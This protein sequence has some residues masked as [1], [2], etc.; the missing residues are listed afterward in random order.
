MVTAHRWT[1]GAVQVA[2]RDAPVAALRPVGVGKAALPAPAGDG[3]GAD[4][5]LVRRVRPDPRPQWPF[6]VSLRCEPRRHR[7]HPPRLRW[8][9]HLPHLHR[10]TRHTQ[11]RPRVLPHH[12]MPQGLDTLGLVAAPAIGPFFLLGTSPCRTPDRTGFLSTGPV[13][14]RTPVNPF[15]RFPKRP[16][17]LGKTPRVS[18]IHPHQPLP[19]QTYPA[20]MRCIP[21]SLH[22]PFVVVSIPCIPPFL[23]F[24]IRCSGPDFATQVAPL[25]NQH[26]GSLRNG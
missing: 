4:A 8:R 25:L 3:V 10:G 23:V 17:G 22:S 16:L 12:H 7:V 20:P 11:R 5:E 18:V 6:P 13:F 21:H 2:G 24:P 9:A 14:F 1:P 19:H 15:Q 26:L